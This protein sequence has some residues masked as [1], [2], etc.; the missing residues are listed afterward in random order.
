MTQ[1]RFKRISTIARVAMLV[2]LI[3]LCNDFVLRIAA[4][5]NAA[6][7]VNWLFLTNPRTVD[8]AILGSSLAKECV[9]PTVLEEQ[10]D[11]QALQLAWGGRG[12]SEQALYWELFLARHQ[13]RTLL[14]ELHPRGLEEGLLT[15]PF[16]EFRYVARLEDPIVWRHV[17]RRYGWLQAS[18][19]R[20][21]PMWSFAHFSTQIG[22]HDVLALR[23]GQTFDPNAPAD[24]RHHVQTRQLEAQRSASDNQPDSTKVSA[25]NVADFKEIVALCE[26]SSV[27]LV[28]FVPPIYQ[29]LT[30]AE[31]ASVARYRDLL[32][33]A[34]PIYTPQGDYLEDPKNFQDA[35]HVNHLGSRIFTQDLAQFLATQ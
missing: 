20:F 25:T 1:R 6:S 15:H 13:T 30:K 19:W 10:L 16:D 12:V 8:V 9:D 21:I 4:R 11:G 33:P 34:V 17:A 14:L 32:G 28:A 35:L 22:W 23:R 31:E 26:R 2:T 27:S 24:N 5:K 29:G 7:R 3:I 18:A